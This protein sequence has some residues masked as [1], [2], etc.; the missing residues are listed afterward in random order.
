MLS[1]Q[2]APDHVSATYTSEQKAVTTGMA[3]SSSWAPFRIRAYLVLWLAQLGANI[4][5]WMQTVG[6]Q[7][8]LV[9]VGA[10]AVFI[11]LVQTATTAPSLLFGLPAGVMADSYD[12]RHVLLTANLIAAGASTLLAVVSFLHVLTPV[13]LLAC[14]FLLGC[15][16]A[17]NAPTWQAVIP[18]LVP[19]KQIPAATALG[20]VTINAARALGPAFAG[21]LVALAGTSAVF[22][23][24]AAAYVLSVVAVL[25]WKRPAKRVGRREPFRSALFSGMRYTKAAP[26]VNRIMLRTALFIVPAS[27]IWALLPV[28]AHGRL[29][30]GSGGYGVLLACLGVGALSGV[31]VLPWLRRR[32]SS[33]KIVVVASIA[34]GAGTVGAAL[35]P[36][37]GVGV[38]LVVAG[39]AWMCNFTTFNSLLQLTLA[40]WVRAR[41]MA[42]YLLIVM[43][44]QA[45][46]SPLWGTIATLWTAQ[47]SFLV[48]GGLLLV[49]VPI[50]V[51]FWPIRPR[52]GEL[53]RSHDLITHNL[54][55]ANSVDPRTGPIEIQVSYRVHPD[56]APAFVTAMDAVRL[57]RM[58]TGANFWELTHRLEDP[59]LFFERYSVPS[60]GEYLLQETQRMTGHDRANLRAA[61]RLTSDEPRV[62]RELPADAP[63]AGVP[64]MPDD[65]D[66]PMGDLR[67]R[68]PD[69]PPA[70]NSGTQN[71]GRQNSERQEPGTQEPPAGDQTA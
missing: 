43:A 35:L 59:G 39:I 6:A 44:G 67:P 33:N 55:M 32:I 31:F 65:E 68:D 8:F 12:R 34:Y 7:W 58:R 10:S 11:T 60:W 15:G 1:A 19:R 22:A 46:G 69:M 56:K 47:I 57:S 27:A 29:H 18:S 14:T 40:P 71:S 45:L 49:F 53:D 30:M 9:E 70:E 5:S 61:L 54:S 41:G 20:S 25:T 38:S 63:I 3:K 24:N 52:T 42:I 37:W 26:H 66:H 48:A 51:R 62:R 50:S 2:S 23:V 16:I 28:E 13:G 21:F 36:S 4:G 64:R 17:L